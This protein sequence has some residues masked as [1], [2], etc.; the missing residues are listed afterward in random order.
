MCSL[1]LPE[2]YTLYLNVF[3]NAEKGSVFKRIYEQTLANDTRPYFDNEKEAVPRLRV[4]DDLAIFYTREGLLHYDQFRCDLIA[5]WMTQYPA[6]LSMAFPKDSRYFEFF[7]HQIFRNFEN[8]VMDSLRKRWTTFP[9]ELCLEEG[10]NSLG[11]EKL[12][13]LFA[14][15]ASASI[16][17]VLIFVL[18]SVLGFALSRRSKSQ[19]TDI[20]FK[21]PSSRQTIY[22][23]QLNRII[24]EFNIQDKSEFVAEVSRTINLVK[25]LRERKGPEARQRI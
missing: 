22:Q 20:T 17:A 18:E 12:V 9:S 16:L 6:V 14:L 23:G 3:R 11:L 1:I 7:R 2:H 13:S 25:K 10:S 5:P 4:E 15:I 21:P 8:G 24:F 19:V